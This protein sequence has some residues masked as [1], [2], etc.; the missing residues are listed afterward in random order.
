MKKN[1]AEK[2]A[3]TP[4]KKSQDRSAQRESGKT[5]LAMDAETKQ[6]IEALE[7]CF[8]L[9]SR[10]IGELLGWPWQSV[11][12]HMKVTRDRIALGTVTEKWVMDVGKTTSERFGLGKLVGDWKAKFAH[13]VK[14]VE[15][16]PESEVEVPGQVIQLVD[17]PPFDDTIGNH[18]LDTTG[19]P[20][21]DDFELELVKLYGEK[22]PEQTP[23][24]GGPLDNLS[25]FPS[26]PS[27]Y[28]S[29]E[30]MQ[31]DDREVR[32]DAPFYCALLNILD[33]YEA[34][35]IAFT[36]MSIDE[37]RGVFRIG[38]DVVRS[39]GFVYER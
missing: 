33:R 18:S 14:S 16:E 29:V 38:F 34:G 5:Y 27:P 15:D 37:V 24:H 4:K 30:P 25:P 28:R 20:P 13:P 22:K 36:D 11:N 21:E 17:N 35:E 3:K 9:N 23:D 32:R 2:S 26:G 7:Y 10:Q 12:A 31:R 6:K 19:Y 39:D 8:D 1:I